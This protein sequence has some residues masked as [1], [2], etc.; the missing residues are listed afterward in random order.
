MLGGFLEGL[1]G[2]VLSQ[3]LPASE[4]R[5]MPRLRC[6]YP[7]SCV[8]AYSDQ[9]KSARVTEM[10]RQGM[11]ME[12]A[13]PYKRGTLVRITYASPHPEA[14]IRCKVRWTRK[15]ATGSHWMGVTYEE[16]GARLDT[17][18]VGYVLHE[19][20]FEDSDVFE[21]RRNIRFP[22]DLLAEV[23]SPQGDLLSNGVVINLGVGGA[24]VE[25]Q[26]SVTADR[27][28]VLSIAPQAGMGPSRLN[29]LS[30]LLRVRSNPDRKNSHL[31]HIRF[32][33]MT[34]AQTRHLGQHLINLLRAASV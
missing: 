30:T 27:E 20:G 25:M 2:L 33:A 8:G 11:R 7:V 28:V 4:R 12:I 21:K 18:W 34:K 31:G 32:Q 22:A 17:S 16:E 6:Y 29:L 15:R 24:L 13:E 23:Q 10:S 1:R 5:T 19:L 26:K 3:G 9:I 14:T